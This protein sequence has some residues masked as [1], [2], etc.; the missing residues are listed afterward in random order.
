[1]TRD[2][3]IG[4]AFL[5][6]SFIAMWWFNWSPPAQRC[7]ERGGTSFDIDGSCLRIEVQKR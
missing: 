6:G 4:L 2:R 7:F 3:K 1:M 5:V